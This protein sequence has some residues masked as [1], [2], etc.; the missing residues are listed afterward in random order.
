MRPLTSEES[1]IGW[2][3]RYWRSELPFVSRHKKMPWGSGRRIQSSGAMGGAPAGR[4]LDG[5]ELAIAP[6]APEAGSLHEGTSP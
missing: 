6:R 4:E 2:A 5:F 3:I 1:L